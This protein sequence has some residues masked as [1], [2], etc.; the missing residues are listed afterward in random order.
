MAVL[1]SELSGVSTL[2]EA[3]V[4]SMGLSSIRTSGRSP[5]DAS[6]AIDVRY[7]GLLG[8]SSLLTMIPGWLFSKLSNTVVR[9]V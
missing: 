9:Y 3:M 5:A 2:Y 4:G 8:I 7:S 1:P 6:S